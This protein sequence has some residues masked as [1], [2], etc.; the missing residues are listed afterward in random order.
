MKCDWAW[1]SY[2]HETNFY[3]L[4]QCKEEVQL[5]R[6]DGV[7]YI[8]LDLTPLLHA[9]YAGLPF[10]RFEAIDVSR[11]DCAEITRPARQWLWDV[12][13]SVCMQQLPASCRAALP[14]PR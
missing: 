5:A 3:L 11:A 14:R 7:S 1:D 4:K 13:V 2:L 9:R 6:Q 12:Y 10:T 8:D